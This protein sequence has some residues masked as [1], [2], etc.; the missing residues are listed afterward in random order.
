MYFNS[1]SGA[2]QTT[3]T[4]AQ[5]AI[6]K[7]DIAAR[8]AAGIMVNF[9]APAIATWYN[10]PQA[11]PNPQPNPALL[12]IPATAQN[13]SMILLKL[14]ALFSQAIT[15]VPAQASMW[16]N[17]QVLITASVTNYVS[18]QNQVFDLVNDPLIQQIISTA[19]SLGNPAVTK[20]S[21]MAALYFPN[22]NIPATINITVGPVLIPGAWIE[23]S[24]VTLATGIN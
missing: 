22:P 21:I 11:I 7:A 20:A 10:N 23:A 9:T 15:D 13:G 17:L 4:A 1:G 14:S 19:I 2:V 16:Q 5:L 3:P 8:Q 12:Q 18:Q 24:D 6:L